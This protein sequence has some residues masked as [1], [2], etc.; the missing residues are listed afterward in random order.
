MTVAWRRGV[1]RNTGDAAAPLVVKLGGSLLTR[2]DWAHEVTS[3]L[4]SLPAPRVIVTGGG[5]LVDGLRAIDR[6][7]P[8]P[9]TLVHRLAIDCMAHTARVTA[10]ALGMPLV[11][12]LDTTVPPTAVLDTPAWLACAGRLDALPVGWHVTSDSIAASVATA[13]GGGLMLVKSVP[14]PHDD[15]GR[16]AEAGWVDEWFPTAAR[17]LAHIAWASP[18]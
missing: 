18:G 14:P 15:I 8:L 3:L 2:V 16:L 1:L 5:P 7:E 12:A 13:R 11:S 6:A 4:E 10:A 17:S 9:E